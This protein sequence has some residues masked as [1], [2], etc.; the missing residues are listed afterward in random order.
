MKFVEETVEKEHKTY[1]T[2]CTGD[3][4]RFVES[5]PMPR[6][7]TPNGY[8]NLSSGVHVDCTKA[9]DAAYYNGRE[10]VLLDATLTFKEM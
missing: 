10:V 5:E 9:V 6:I 7:K 4:F 1:K 2:L 8:T 3:V